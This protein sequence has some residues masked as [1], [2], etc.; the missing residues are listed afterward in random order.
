LTWK[1]AAAG[2]HAHT[3]GKINYFS[4]TLDYG[5]FNDLLTSM[6]LHGHLLALSI[7][8]YNEE[9]PLI[10]NGEKKFV[11]FCHRKIMSS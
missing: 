2:F 8:V 4:E 6:C 11:I 1:P 10:C 9:I 5:F 7:V 3:F